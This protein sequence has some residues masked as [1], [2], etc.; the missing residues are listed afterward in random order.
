MGDNKSNDKKKKE[1]KKWRKI[2]LKM[3]RDQKKSERRFM[4]AQKA[5]KMDMRERG[6]SKESNK[7]SQ[8]LNNDFKSIWR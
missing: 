3:D 8:G 1:E 4:E 6:K 2:L 5:I 7:D